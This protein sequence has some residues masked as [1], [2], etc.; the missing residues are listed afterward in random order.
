VGGPVSAGAGGHDLTIR[1]FEPRDLEVFARFRADPVSATMAFGS[2]R[3]PETLDDVARFVRGMA[4][5]GSY[6][7]I[8]ADRSG[9]AVGYSSL[10]SVDRVN[11]TI[12]TGSGVLD[13][14]RRGAGL[15]TLGRRLVLDRLFNEME[16]RRVY[17]EF[18]AFNE[19]SRRSH[20]KLGAEIVGRRRQVH[21]ASGVYHDSVVYMVR[22]ERFNELFPPDPHRH[23]GGAR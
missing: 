10:D 7:W 3:M 8:W 23:T 19:A 9:E 15:G 16:Y 2:V 18:A 13:P 11:R 4:E 22:C 14:A 6:F 20:A 1:A 12:Q 21:F 5:S 17:G